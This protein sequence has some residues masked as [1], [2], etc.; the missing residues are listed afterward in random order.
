MFTHTPSHL[1]DGPAFA[2]CFPSD[3]GTNVDINLLNVPPEKARRILV[4]LGNTEEDAQRVVDYVLCQG[5]AH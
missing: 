4:I 5:T 2:K 3:N 1:P